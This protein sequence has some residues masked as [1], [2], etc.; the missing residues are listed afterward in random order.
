[1]AFAKGY[2]GVTIL[3]DGK[4]ALIL[5]LPELVTYMGKSRPVQA[6]TKGAA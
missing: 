6:P 1:M 2:S 4:P 3:G 5:E